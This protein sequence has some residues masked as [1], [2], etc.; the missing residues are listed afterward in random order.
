MKMIVFILGVTILAMTFTNKAYAQQNIPNVDQVTYLM[1]V[2][3]RDSPIIAA[4]RKEDVRRIECC[5]FNCLSGA[6]IDN[7]PWMIE[8]EICQKMIRE[9]G[10]GKDVAMCANVDG[11]MINDYF[12]LK[13]QHRTDK[14]KKTM[15]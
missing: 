3:E 13:K 6:I 7:L 9:L 10:A 2:A 4:S 1:Y 5:M 11:T 15:P 12:T 14:L 8:G